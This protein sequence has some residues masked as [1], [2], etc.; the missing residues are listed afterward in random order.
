MDA[1]TYALDALFRGFT[2][3]VFAAAQLESWDG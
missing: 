2:D 3:Y 1:Y